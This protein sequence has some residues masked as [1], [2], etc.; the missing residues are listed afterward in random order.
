MKKNIILHANPIIMKQLLLTFIFT[1]LVTSGATAQYSIHSCSGDVKIKKGMRLIPAEKG[2][3]VSP[4][5]ILELAE[6]AEIEI[7][8]ATNSQTYKCGKPGQ[9][10]VSGIMISTTTLS[11]DKGKSIR[12]NMNFS[13]SSASGS[14]H[15]YVESGMVKRSMATYDPEARNIEV[16]PRQLSFCVINAL[17]NP[18]SMQ[19][20]ECPADFSHAPTP[21]GG[22]GFTVGNTMASPIY[23]NVLKVKDDSIAGI[24]IS[25][26]GQPSGSYVLL[27]SQTISREQLTPLPTDERHI[28]IMTHFHFDIDK[29]IEQIESIT[30]SNEAGIPDSSLKVYLSPL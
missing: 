21:G 18:G 20:N 25:E 4:A 15:V 13:R 10:S 5:D 17:R 22:L 3:T 19:G 23:F 1:I 30:K 29:L 27:P 6:G 12:D 26:L 14:S 28:L 2:V 16:D 11:A 24:S 7:F 9:T 8:N